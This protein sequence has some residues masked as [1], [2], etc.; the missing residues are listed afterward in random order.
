MEIPDYL[1]VKG[2]KYGVA[3]I[4]KCAFKNCANL[5]SA[6]LNCHLVE[7]CSEA[8]AGTSLTGTL[9]LP[10]GIRALGDKPFY[11]TGIT[12]LVLP[13]T[14]GANFYTSLHTQPMVSTSVFQGM[15]ALKDLV[16]RASST[17]LGDYAWDISSIPADC[18]IL[19]PEDKV[20]DFKNHAVWSAR[21]D[22]IE[23][24]AYD[25]V[26]A[27]SYPSRTAQATYDDDSGYYHVIVTSSMHYAF[28]GTSYSGQCKYVY[29]PSIG[30]STRSMV[31]GSEVDRSCGG[32]KRYL[33]TEIGDSAFAGAQ[34]TSLNIP[35]SIGKIGHHAF[36]NSKVSGHIDVPATVWSIGRDAFAYCEDIQ[37]LRF[38]RTT[39]IPFEEQI[40]GANAPG[41]ECRIPLEL[42]NQYDALMADWATYGNDA[43]SPRQHLVPFFSTDEPTRMF[44]TIVP[45]D[46]DKAVID[47]VY[48]ASDYD[49]ESTTV[50]LSP[51]R[52][53]P[54]NTGVLLCGLQPYRDYILHQPDEDPEDIAVNYFAPAATGAVDVNAQTVGF[55][56]SMGDNHFIRP[57]QEHMIAES[58]AYLLLSDV[59]ANDTEVVYTRIAEPVEPG[60]LDGDGV[61]D[62][63]DLNYVIEIILGNLSADDPMFSGQADLNGDK[64]VDGSDLNILIDIILGR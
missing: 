24:G 58:Y 39:G 3:S 23:R 55:Y 13:G 22:Y 11:G 29:H 12:R 60:D 33:V 30:Q 50:V 4:D 16:L 48:I 45:I 40:F 53:I 36:N 15:T 59:E 56:W 2:Q 31:N 64:S 38:R 6:L 52:T 17:M 44:S 5:T 35:A 43:K 18:R 25:F 41:F 51:V 34:F 10:Y 26:C 7:I 54:A 32:T 47:E 63:I 46:F 20:E 14:V 49:A 62:A 61:V 19:V 8:F 28:Q 57:T 21:A 9:S 1:T 42:I 37:S 27:P